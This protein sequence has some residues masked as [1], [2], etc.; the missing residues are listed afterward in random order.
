MEEPDR[1]QV[2]RVVLEVLKDLEASSRPRSGRAPSGAGRD[3]ATRVLFLFNA[4]V[5]KLDEALEQVRLIE[6]SGVKS[7][8]YTGPSA[9]GWVCGGDVRDATG[10]R[11]ILDTVAPEGVD[12]VLQRADVLVLPTLCLTVAAKVAGL[13]C[14]DQES[15]LVLS[16]LLQGKKVLAARDGF[17]ICD[18]LANDRIRDEVD[19]VLGKLETFGAV[20]SSTSELNEAFRQVVSPEAEVKRP[21]PGPPLRLITAK[22]ITNAVNH[23]QHTLLLA[24]GGLI[25]PL[26]RDLAKEHGVD[27]EKD[28]KSDTGGPDTGK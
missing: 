27:I 4:G 21:D 18:L 26:A 25:T 13:A 16:A 19:R 11:C 2:R 14:D 12:T 1:E 6:E 9:R 7:G 15:R 23:R 3:A 20:F 28:R 17:L 8:V 5:R 22:A 24:P 10:A